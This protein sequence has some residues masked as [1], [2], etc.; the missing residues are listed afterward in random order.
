MS[1]TAPVGDI[2]DTTPSE[3]PG[4]ARLDGRFCRILHRDGFHPVLHLELPLLEHRL[5]DLLLVAEHDLLGQGPEAI[6]EFVMLFVQP[7]VLLVLAE[8]GLLE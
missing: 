3:R 5:F 2:V 6:V 4:A 1:E 8:E 7:A